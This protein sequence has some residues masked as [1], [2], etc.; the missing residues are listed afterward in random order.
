MVPEIDCFIGFPLEEIS[1]TEA[2]STAAA[3]TSSDRLAWLSRVCARFSSRVAAL[4]LSL[5]GNSVDALLELSSMQRFSL[6]VLHPVA[7]PSGPRA[8]KPRP[9]R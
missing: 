7:M 6:Q 5:S 1:L 3:V 2:A 4:R 8:M 9:L